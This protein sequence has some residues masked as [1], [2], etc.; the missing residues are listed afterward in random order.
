MQE[1]LKLS[2]DQ[3]KQLNELQK[4]DDGK[5]AKILT[6][7]QNKQ[8]SDMR[9]MFTRGPGGCGGGRGGRG[10]PGGFGPSGFGGGRPPDVVYRWQVYCLDRSTGKTADV[11]ICSAA[12]G[13]GEVRRTE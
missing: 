6:E 8:L 13:A 1:Q 5:L 11:W 9:Q 10:G 4:E 7:E 2:D 12:E 3:K